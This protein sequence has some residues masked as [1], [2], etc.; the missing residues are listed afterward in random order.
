MLLIHKLDE[1]RRL[2]AR[3]LGVWRKFVRVQSAVMGELYRLKLQ[4][5]KKSTPN[6]CFDR[7]S[8][9]RYYV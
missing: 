8:R 9:K 4:E 3:G 7:P 2:V 5:M 6:P 1:K